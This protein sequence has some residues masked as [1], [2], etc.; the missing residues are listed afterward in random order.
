[1]SSPSLP[2]F[3]CFK[4]V[5]RAFVLLKHFLCAEEEEQEEEAVAAAPALLLQTRHPA[6]LVSFSEA[7]RKRKTKSLGLLIPL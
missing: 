6:R 5:K 7:H 2:F 1:V 4:T 3:S